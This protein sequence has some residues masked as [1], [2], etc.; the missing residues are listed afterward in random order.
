MKEW[1]GLTSFH[2]G[3]QKRLLWGSIIYLLWDLEKELAKQRIVES[4][5]SR[6][7]N[8]CKDSCSR[9][10]PHQQTELSVSKG[11]KETSMAGQ[12]ARWGE[13]RE[14]KQ[15]RNGF[16]RITL[17]AG[18]AQNC[19]KVQKVQ[20]FLIHIIYKMGVPERRTALIQA[21][22]RGLQ[23]LLSDSS[24]IFNELPRLHV[25]LHR[26]TQEGFLGPDLP[27]GLCSHFLHIPL[28]GT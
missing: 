21:V 18:T 23:L 27:W 3:G 15:S 1:Q 9:E 22:F 10:R 17:A 2:L 14:M 20:T 25:C 8:K 28:A 16:V 6:G 7:K 12:P 24:V 5:R 13:W 26:S 19:I 4:T 11:L